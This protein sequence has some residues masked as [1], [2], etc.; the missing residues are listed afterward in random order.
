MKTPP[1][2]VQFTSKLF[3]LPKST[4]HCST[5]TGFSGFFAQLN[6]VVL[7]PRRA[8]EEQDLLR[9]IALRPTPHCISGEASSA[10]SRLL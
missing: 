6:G 2:L 7:K 9:L 10:S 3:F 5:A 8:G 4:I 1:S